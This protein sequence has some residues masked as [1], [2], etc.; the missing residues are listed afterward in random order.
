M[1]VL[2]WN[3]HCLPISSA[4]SMKFWSSS[5]EGQTPSSLFNELQSSTAAQL[6][7]LLRNKPTA[8][9]SYFS[10]RKYVNTCILC[11]QVH[12]LF[13]CPLFLKED[14]Q[15]RLQIVKTHHH[16]TNCLS[17]HKFSK[18]QSRFS[19][20]YCNKWHRTL[21]HIVQNNAT[22]DTTAIK[23]YCAFQSTQQCQVLLPTA[24][25]K[26][27]DS[28]GNL[29]P[30]RAVLDSASQSNFCTEQLVKKLNLRARKCTTPLQGFNSVSTYGELETNLEIH[31]CV[32][33]FKLKAN[34]FVLPTIT[35]N[36][37]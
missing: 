2:S 23:T 30:C 14:P 6:K 5:K 36:L 1:H 34:C 20:R 18:C 32:N 3:P 25:V 24:I 4:Q 9:Q 16:C 17:N 7:L 26:I 29:I 31:S 37:P 12:R 15:Q 33:D 35:N 13:K 19:C 22:G 10:T 27:R 11:N 21:L 8:N 28:N